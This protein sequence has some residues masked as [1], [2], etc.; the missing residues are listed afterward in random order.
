ME[1]KGFKLRHTKEGNVYDEIDF[2]GERPYSGEGKSGMVKDGEGSENT[3]HAAS[4]AASDDSGEGSEGSLCKV[5]HEDV[6]KNSATKL[7]Q[8]AFTPFTGGDT[9][10]LKA[11]PQAT[12]QGGERK[13]FP[14]TTE[15]LPSP[16][17]IPEEHRQLFTEYQ[18]KVLS[19]PVATLIWRA[20][21]SGFKNGIFGREDHIK[22][23][24]SLL[25]SGEER[26]EKGAVEA[27]KRT[28]GTW[29]D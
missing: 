14:F 21:D 5:P 26:K 6:N 10:S 18:A 27:M 3:F 15:N 9:N 28:L 23:T 20:S 17:A 4:E 29:E 12:L 19:N 1:K 13:N 25:R 8:S 16:D 11:A 7:S 24:S 2:I 22:Y